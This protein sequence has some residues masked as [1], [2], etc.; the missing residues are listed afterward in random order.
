R[1]RPGLV[2]RVRARGAPVIAAATGEE[3]VAQLADLLGSAGGT[4]AD[5]FL[6]AAERGNEATALPAW[7]ERNAVRALVH[8]R[9]YLTALQQAA[10]ATGAGDVVHLLGWRADAE[11][12]LATSRAAQ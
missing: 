3:I 4:S 8:G 12:L 7:T 10:D 1:P 11:Q 2:D 5:W 6:T 9:R